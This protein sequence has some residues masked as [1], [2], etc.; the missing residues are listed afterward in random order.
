MAVECV[1]LVLSIAG[2]YEGH[3]RDRDKVVSKSLNNVQ[4]NIESDDPK[5]LFTLTSDLAQVISTNLPQFQVLHFIDGL[6][7]SLLDCEPSSSNGTSVV[8]NI[9]LKN[10][11]N[12]IQ[13]QVAH[14]AEAILGQLDKIQCPRTKSSTLRALSSLASHHSRIVGGILLMQP[15]P[16]DR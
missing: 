8:L 6:C 1:C 9:V 16:Y 14:V 13:N 15:L 12:E 11:G 7:E 3:M 4:Q 2:R 5:L 10:K